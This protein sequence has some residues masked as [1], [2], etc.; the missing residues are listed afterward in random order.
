[1][2]NGTALS[3]AQQA[4]ALKDLFPHVHAN[5]R[6]GRLVW[7]GEIQPTALSRVYKVQ[8]TYSVGSVPSVKVL[9]PP[10]ERRPDAKLPHLYDNGALCLYEAGEWQ[11]SMLIVDTILPW[12]SEWLAH[13]EIWRANGVWYG[14]GGSPAIE[15]PVVNP[16]PAVEPD[17]SA[18]GVAGP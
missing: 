5:L 16:A 12:T 10:L 13:Y 1:M 8:V 9:D 4:F 7:I 17:P 15:T 18:A 3:V 14:G 2:R 6:P 11:P